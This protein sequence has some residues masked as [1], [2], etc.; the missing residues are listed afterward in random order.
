MSEQ[1]ADNLRDDI[2]ETI[3]KWLANN[4]GGMLTGFAIVVNYFDSDGD[5]AWATATSQ[6]QSPSHTMAVEHDVM[7]YFD[8]DCEGDL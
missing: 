7:A 8:H 2:D 3:G 6:D 5:Q 4:G 1:T